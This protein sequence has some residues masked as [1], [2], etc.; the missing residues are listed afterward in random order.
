MFFK[1]SGQLNLE[2][3]KVGIYDDV[4]PNEAE[5]FK[6]LSWLVK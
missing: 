3:N 1:I 4:I 2:M 5:R 6:S